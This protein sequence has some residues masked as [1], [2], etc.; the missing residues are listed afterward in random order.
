M[1][2]Y[3]IIL[4]SLPS[5]FAQYR[6]A[7]VLLKYKDFLEQGTYANDDWSKFTKL[8]ASRYETFKIVFEHFE[9]N[10]GQVIVELGTSRSY[11]HGG[12]LGCNSDDTKYWTPDQPENWDWGAGFFTGV[13]LNVYTI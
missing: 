11:V 12:L 4:L 3:V 9:N 10:N 13:A 2:K 7:D 8:P 6:C 1:K 5:V